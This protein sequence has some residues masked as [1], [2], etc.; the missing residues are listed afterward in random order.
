M[1]LPQG[2]KFEVVPSSFEEN[3]DKS[4]FKHVYDYVK[5]TARGK[6]LEVANRLAFDPRV[7]Q[8]SSLSHV[9]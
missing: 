7:C 3:L 1:C 2:L 8:V 5:E 9:S 6:A 4:S